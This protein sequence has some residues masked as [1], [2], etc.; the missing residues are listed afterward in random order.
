MSPWVRVYAAVFAVGCGGG[1]LV[2]GVAGLYDGSDLFLAV[3]AVVV[4]AA[5]AT[6]AGGV[7]CA[8]WIRPRLL[9]ADEDD[10]RTGATR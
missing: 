4:T 10:E 1:V 8:F 2:Y 9:G 7:I 6:T 5:T 3:P